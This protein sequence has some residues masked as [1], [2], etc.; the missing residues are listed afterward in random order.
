MDLSNSRFSFVNPLQRPATP[1]RGTEH[2]VGGLS[3]TDSAMSVLSVG[4]RPSALV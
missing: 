1:G 4:G 3:H 2:S